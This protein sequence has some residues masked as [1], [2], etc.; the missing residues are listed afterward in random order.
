M[1]VG[2]HGYDHEA[3]P[4]QTFLSFQSRPQ[5]EWDYSEARHT[6]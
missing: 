3:C 6:G 4:Y 2:G 5:F 1:A